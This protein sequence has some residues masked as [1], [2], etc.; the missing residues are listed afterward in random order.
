MAKA[1]NFEEAI[2]NRTYVLFALGTAVYYSEHCRGLTGRG[3]QYL[4]RAMILHDLR[5]PMFTGDKMYKEGYKVAAGY[6]SCSKLR[7]DITDAG[8]GAM[9]R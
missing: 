8:L 6:P 4:T 7:N 3:M 2:Q 9:V 5:A 1:I